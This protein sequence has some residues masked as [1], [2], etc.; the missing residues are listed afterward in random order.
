MTVLYTVSIVSRACQDD[1]ASGFQERSYSRKVNK[2]FDSFTSV[3]PGRGYILESGDHEQALLQSC[4]L[5]WRSLRRR[6]QPCLYVHD[7]GASGVGLHQA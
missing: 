7:I 4:S 2:A 6:V 5:L 3:K 1:K